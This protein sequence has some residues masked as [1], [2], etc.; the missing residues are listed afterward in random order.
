MEWGVQLSGLFHWRH[1]GCERSLE[2]VGHIDIDEVRAADRVAGPYNEAVRLVPGMLL[3]Q[4]L[5]E[6]IVLERPR[7]IQS[8]SVDVGVQ[9]RSKLAGLVQLLEALI[10]LSQLVATRWIECDRR[11]ALQ[12]V[13]VHIEMQQQR[14][15]FAIDQR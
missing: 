5:V 15:C 9:R 3:N 8:N 14:N 10:E 12:F 11:S 1:C 2:R 13:H 7:Q 4:L 6:V